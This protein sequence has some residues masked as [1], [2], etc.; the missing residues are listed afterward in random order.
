M[1]ACCLACGGRGPVGW[2]ACLLGCLLAGWRL[3]P[4]LFAWGVV[5]W[6][7]VLAVSYLSTCSWTVGQLIGR[8]P[9][10]VDRVHSLRT[11]GMQPA[12]RLLEGLFVCWTEYRWQGVNGN[13][14]F[15]KRP[16]KQMGCRQELGLQNGCG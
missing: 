7:P 8:G 11:I 16:G 6:L 10:R 1:L 12:C 5:A 15:G 4:S 2:L 9:F 3:F 14:R 13:G